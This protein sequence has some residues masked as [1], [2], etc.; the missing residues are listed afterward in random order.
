MKMIKLT[1]KDGTLFCVNSLHTVS[2]RPLL[3]E[4]PAIT[5]VET[6]TVEGAD[7]LATEWHVQE[8]IEQILTQ[9]EE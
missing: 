2:L 1:R 7:N 5:I 8:S 4:E 9:I 3:N 6:T